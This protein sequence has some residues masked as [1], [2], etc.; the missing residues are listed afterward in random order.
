MKVAVLAFP[1]VQM[2]DVVGPIDV[3][4][5]AA[6]QAGNPGAYTF[7]II[8]PERGEVRASNGMTFFSDAGIASASGDIDTLLVAGSPKMREIE[9][10][11]AL[12]SWLVQQSKRVR[13]LGAVCS[14][15]FLLARAGLLDGKRATT[16][17]NAST[18]LASTFPAVTVEPDRI[19]IK[20]GA[21]YTSAGVTAGMDLAL[22]LVEEDFGRGVALKVAREF[23][24]FLKRPGGQSQFSAHLAAQTAEKSVIRDV[25]NWVLENIEKPLSVD[26]LALHAGMSTRNFARMFKRESNTTPAEFVEGARL[27]AARRMLEETANPLKRVAALCGFG[28]PNSLRR[29]FVRRLGVT[30]AD[31]R[32]RF[33]TAT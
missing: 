21:T 31:Y 5:E 14:G 3:F 26:H 18:R 12:L 33:R 4:N 27:D 23:V 8:T 30:P 7:E 1:G 9:E 20:D 17:W 2:L 32:R 28:D 19:Y 10:Q 11:A 13:R 24:M 6:R 16:H 29:A 22:A 25:Q 15:A